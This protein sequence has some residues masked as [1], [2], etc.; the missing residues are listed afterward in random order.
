VT[1]GVWVLTTVGA[2]SADAV[3]SADL[4]QKSSGHRTDRLL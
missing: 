4:W 2:G 1:F 3:V